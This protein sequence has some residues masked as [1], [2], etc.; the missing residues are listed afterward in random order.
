MPFI[1]KRAH[2]MILT[3]LL[4][5]PAAFTLMYAR[6]YLAVD[7]ALD[8]VSSEHDVILRERKWLALRNAQLRADDVDA[9]DHF[10]DRVLDLNSSVELKK[11]EVSAHNIDKKLHR[12]GPD[13][14][15]LTAQVDG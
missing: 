6:E 12:S 9:G 1:M 13:V 7:S 8:A 3:V 11:Q 5:A 15:E 4:M 2:G 10:G 14:A